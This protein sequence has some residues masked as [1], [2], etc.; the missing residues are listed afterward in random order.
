MR[1]AAISHA[2]PRRPPTNADVLDAHARAQPRP[3]RRG[4]A[5]GGR[6]AVER[7]PRR[8]RDGRAYRLADDEKA[9]D[10]VLRASREALAQAGVAAADVDL[11][12]LRGRRPRLDRAGH[13]DGDPGRARAERATSFDVLDACAAGCGPCTS[14]TAISRRAPTGC[15]LDRRAASAASIAPR[16]LRLRRRARA[17]STASPP[18]PSAR[19]RRRPSWWRIG[20]TTTALFAFRTFPSTPS[21]ACCPSR[22]WRTSIPASRTFAACRVVSSRSPARW[23]RRARAGWARCGNRCRS[24]GR[25]E[26]DIGFGH[27]PSEPACALVARRL[28]ME[29]RYFPTHR[30]TATPSRPRFRWA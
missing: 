5:R 10:V 14:R 2:L 4:F 12:H 9:I 15:A 30:D 3:A 6:R 21:C 17:S 19:R 29:D 16:R 24:S 11:V 28:G 27:N 26:H 25:G 20:A 7:L 23:W 8:R 13:G 22:R 18:S 1:I